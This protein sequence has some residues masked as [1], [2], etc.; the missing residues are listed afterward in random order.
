MW[1][2][3]ADRQ[4]SVEETLD[5]SGATLATQEV[6]FDGPQTWI[7]TTKDGQTQ[8]VHTTG[9]T[10]TK[11][12]DDPS[13]ESN[14]TDVLAKYS[15]NKQCMTAQLQGEATTAGRA[16]YLINV[17]PRP[18]V[19]A[20]SIAVG[21]YQAGQTRQVTSGGRYVGRMQVWLD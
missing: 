3:G 8:V 6:V 20:A 19:C 13:P 15:Q 10:W 21:G 12:A 2:G 4:S 5:A 16:S 17:T 1:F 9:T 18:G 7:A 14:L 11:P